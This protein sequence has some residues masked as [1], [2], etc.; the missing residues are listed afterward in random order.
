M[1]K[2]SERGIMNNKIFA[3]VLLLVAIILSSA[4]LL[5][6]KESADKSKIE[7]EFGI[8]DP[9]GYTCSCKNGQ[10]LYGPYNDASSCNADCSKLTP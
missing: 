6:E 2:K 1:R 5:A 9:N 8:F 10:A 7:T 4:Y 3:V